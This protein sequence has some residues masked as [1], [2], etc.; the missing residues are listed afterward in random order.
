MKRFTSLWRLPS[1]LIAL[2]AALTALVIFGPP[3]AAAAPTVTHVSTTVLT[4][5]GRT[6][7]TYTGYMNGESFQQDGIT[8]YAGWQYAAF[9]DESGYVNLS[10][11]KLSSGAWQNLRLT[12]YRT[13]STDSHKIGRAHV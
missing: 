5:Q 7:L 9:W 12:D 6:A 13:T 3:A 1:T 11:R 8:T 2:T 10:R 4:T